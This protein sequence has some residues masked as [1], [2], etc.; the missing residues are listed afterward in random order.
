MPA[1]STTDAGATK[2]CGFS[3]ARAVSS[4]DGVIDTTSW[5]M[6][7]IILIPEIKTGKNTPQEKNPHLTC[8]GIDAMKL[9]NESMI[10]LKKY[11]N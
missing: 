9:Q 11:S 5:V 1:Q 6:M 10:T 8:T 3:L 4:P 7:I 2:V